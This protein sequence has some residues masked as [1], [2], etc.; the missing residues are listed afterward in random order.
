MQNGKKCVPT[1]PGINVFINTAEFQSAIVKNKFLKYSCYY[2]AKVS[3]FKYICT[4]SLATLKTFDVK[5]VFEYME[6]HDIAFKRTI[7]TKII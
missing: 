2:K 3:I 5:I 6:F 7:M 4:F 1:S